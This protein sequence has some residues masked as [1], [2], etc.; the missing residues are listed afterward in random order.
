MDCWCEK[1]LDPFLSSTTNPTST[2]EATLRFFSFPLVL[3]Y[4][5]FFFFFLVCRILRYVGQPLF[6]LDSH[7]KNHFLLLP[8][9][10]PSTSSRPLLEITNR[11]EVEIRHLLT[12]RA[13]FPSS[14]RATTELFYVLNPYI[15]LLISVLYDIIYKIHSSS[16]QDS[17][18]QP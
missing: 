10:F 18:S 4:S 9:A 6:K 12:L 2:F 5:P 13:F 1:S 17:S 8:P 16:S 15:S 14:P 3:P 11:A 7:N